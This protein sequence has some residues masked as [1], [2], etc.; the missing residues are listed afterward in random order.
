MR[1]FILLW[2]SVSIHLSGA[3]LSQTCS[4]ISAAAALVVSNVHQR[5]NAWSA[6]GKLLA[7]LCVNGVF[8]HADELLACAAARLAGHVRTRR[9]CAAAPDDI[10]LTSEYIIGQLEDVN[11]SIKAIKTGNAATLKALGC[12]PVEL[13]SLLARKAQLESIL[14]A[15]VP[16]KTSEQLNKQSNTGKYVSVVFCSVSG[17]RTAAHKLLTAV[18]TL[19]FLVYNFRLLC[20]VNA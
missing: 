20:G 19:S 18:R 15:N 11:Q 13:D 2:F 6:L 8:T 17:L 14:F 10:R 7:Q 12:T 3:L 5:S 16:P 4:A 1:F 9:Y